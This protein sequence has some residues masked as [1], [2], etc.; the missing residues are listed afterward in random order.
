MLPNMRVLTL[1]SYGETSEED[2][3]VT[4]S[5]MNIKMVA[6]QDGMVQNRPVKVTTILFMDDPEHV[7]LNLSEFDLLQIEGIVGA[8]GFMEQ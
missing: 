7:T 8:Y 2:F 4:L 3:R 1:H 6:A 5:V